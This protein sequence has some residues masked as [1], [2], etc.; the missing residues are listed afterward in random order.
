MQSQEEKWLLEEKYDGVESFAFH[1]DLEKLKAGTPLAYL[2]GSIPFLDCTIYLDS[3]PL[4]PRSETEFWTE[5]AIEAINK[6]THTGDHTDTSHNNKVPRS[7]LG[8][9][10]GRT[11]GK[12][13]VLDLCAGS[14]AIG[15]AVAKALPEALVTFGE[16]DTSHYS[17]INRTI[18]T[19]DV[20]AQTTVIISDLF[21]NINNVFDFILTNPPYIDPAIDRAEASVKMHEPHLALY[22]G[23]DGMECIAHIIAA[24]PQYLSA[25]GQLWIEHE[26]EQVAAI[27]TCAA[28]NQLHAV[29]CNDQY[30][31]P[32]YSVLTH[33]VAE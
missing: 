17:T 15:T 19:N 16:I 22:G 12:V 8:S 33:S 18:E 31:T 30:D 10:P 32:R 23:I 21:E 24:A 14:G 28:E 1:A 25:N 13:K 6:Y 3:H 2:I 26:P 7:D 20:R 9:S 27:A 29:T 11:S 4:I 5:K